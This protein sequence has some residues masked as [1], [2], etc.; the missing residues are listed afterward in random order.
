MTQ[1]GVQGSGPL[2]GHVP[3]PGH[4]RRIAET[5][6]ARAVSSGGGQAAVRA[7]FPTNDSTAML[8]PVRQ[9]ATAVKSG[10]RRAS[11]R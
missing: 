8:G 2:V 10:R 3:D 4:F 1:F 6:F 9:V 11:P 7:S 5:A